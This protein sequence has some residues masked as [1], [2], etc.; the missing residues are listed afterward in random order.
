VRGE[1]PAG[2]GHGILEN[3]DP[4]AEDQVAGDEDALAFV[5]L[6]QEGEGH[7]HFVAALLD[8]ADVV[9]DHGVID[10]ESGKFSF[11][12][13]VALGSQ[14]PLDERKGRREQDPVAVPDELVADGSYDVALASGNSFW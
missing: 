13:K 11:E 8:V 4:I 1:D 5:P 12:A 7:L 6:G 9:E 3:A 2:G 10:V 14:Q